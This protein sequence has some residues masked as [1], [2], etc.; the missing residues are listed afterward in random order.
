MNSNEFW[1][2]VQDVDQENNVGSSVKT[3]NVQNT[4]CN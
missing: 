3:D 1:A 2:L 4:E